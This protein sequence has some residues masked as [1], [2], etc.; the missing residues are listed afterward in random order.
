MPDTGTGRVMFLAKRSTHATIPAS[1]AF[2]RGAS[3]DPVAA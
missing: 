2:L 1:S 3:G